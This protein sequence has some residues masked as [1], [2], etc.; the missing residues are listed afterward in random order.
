MG[1]TIE[2]ILLYRIW[3]IYGLSFNFIISLDV[4]GFDSLI[5]SVYDIGKDLY[6]FFVSGEEMI[7]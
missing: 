7:I 4:G 6:S 1:A 2:A 5:N 3:E